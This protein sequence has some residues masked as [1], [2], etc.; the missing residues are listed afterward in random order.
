[1]CPES[2]CFL[3]KMSMFAVVGVLRL[4]V[5]IVSFHVL[6]RGAFPNLDASVTEHAQDDILCKLKQFQ[7]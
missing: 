1:M 7:V 3:R 2:L 6:C 4:K 5:L